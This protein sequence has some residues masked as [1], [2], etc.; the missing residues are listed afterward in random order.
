[1]HRAKSALSI[2]SFPTGESQTHSLGTTGGLNKNKKDWKNLNSSLIV[3]GTPNSS[4][5]KEK[6]LRPFKS[7]ILDM[8]VWSLADHDWILPKPT[9]LK[10]VLS[11]WKGFL[12][13]HVFTRLEIFRPESQRVCEANAPPPSY[14]LSSDSLNLL[15]ATSPTP[16]FT[17]STQRELN[18]LDK[19]IAQVDSVHYA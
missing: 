8:Q 16:A 14:V 18:F 5:P 9:K 6:N 13:K 2:G 10:M 11:N 1:M 17:P 15:K 12:S 3:C 4:H 19:I 7:G